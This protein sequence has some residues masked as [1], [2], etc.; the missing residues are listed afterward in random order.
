MSEKLRALL[1]DVDGTLAD[2]ERDGH[3]V[4]FNRAFAD[5]G[6]DWNWSVELYGEL[7]AVT[8]GKE[9]IRHFLERYHPG[10]E[11]PPDLTEFVAG[12]HA[13][14]TRH[15][16]RMLTEGGIPLRSGV[17]RL[18]KEAKA[19]GLRL[20][21]ATTTT[22]DNV[23]ALLASTLGEE[24]AVLF[25]CIGA[26]DV[27]PAKKPAPDIYCYVLE[28]MGLDPAECVAFEDSENGL[29]SAVD[30]Q[31]TTIVT[32]NDY[33]RSHDFGGAALVVDRFGEPG[34]PFDLID[35]EAG[36]AAYVDLALVRRVH[37]A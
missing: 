34:E 15:Y 33:T 6:L 16:V 14:K 2:T 22:P 23:T 32:T 4:A 37:S 1:F 31:L 3:R 10:F 12:L 29:R 36:D 26:G 20:A 17:E 27:V 35:G 11:A 19:A 7:L 5:A 25:E 28:K 9:R 8:G 13:A 24:G 21:I 18:L 30:A